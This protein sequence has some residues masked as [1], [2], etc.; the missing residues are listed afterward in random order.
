MTQRR[1]LV[2]EDERAIREMVCFNL[3]R[4]GYR[5]GPRVTR[6]RRAPRSP[7]GDPISC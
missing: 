3:G 5:C 4:A 7:I 6:A 2:V 1:I